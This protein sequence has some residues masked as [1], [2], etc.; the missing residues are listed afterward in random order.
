M[1]QLVTQVG[2]MFGNEILTGIG[3]SVSAIAESGEK[4]QGTTT[5]FRCPSCQKI[6][7]FQVKKSIKILKC[8]CSYSFPIV[9]G[10]HRCTCNSLFEPVNKAQEISACPMCKK[11]W[12]VQQTTTVFCICECE[13]VFSF[14][15][16]KDPNETSS[17]CQQPMARINKIFY[18]GPTSKVLSEAER[19]R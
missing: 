17:C 16:V 13:N 19:N 7:H 15:A 11:F 14:N 9:H 3:K 10:I 8:E 18:M 4:R 12:K 1:M 5:D 6:G 2:R